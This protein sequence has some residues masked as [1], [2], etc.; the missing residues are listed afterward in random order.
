MYQIPGK[1][2]YPGVITE[3]SYGSTA[4]TIHSTPGN[5]TKLNTARYHR[6]YK[7]EDKDAMGQKNVH[8]GFSD[9]NLF[10]AQT[11]SPHISGLYQHSCIK[12][13]EP[14]HHT[15]TTCTD[16]EERFT[17]AIPLEVV[18]LTPLL[19]WNPYNIQHTTSMKNAD[20]HHIIHGPNGTR[21]GG[22]TKDKA[23]NGTHNK[24][25]YRTP[26]EFFSSK[27]S[28]DHDRAD[29]A[30]GSVGVL[31]QQGQVRQM[32]ASGIRIMLPKIEG[33]GR[34]RTRWPIVPI[35]AEGQHTRKE[36]EALKDMVMNMPTYSTL[37]EEMPTSVSQANKLFMET[38]HLLKIPP[39]SR[40]PP[41]LHD[42]DLVIHE[43]DIES[44]KQG[45]TVKGVL[46]SISNA[47]QHSVDIK[48][49]G[50]NTYI[51]TSCDGMARCWDGHDIHLS[52]ES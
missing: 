32:V 50:N 36:L 34:I 19:T 37:F 51:M 17:Y 16:L 5:M 8:R 3:S 23:Y 11:T 28:V 21:N 29:T 48:M 45:N 41:G 35:H 52:V 4:Y 24:L 7:I 6:W 39:T 46:S 42:H 25:Y 44:M 26:V 15:V 33:V 20:I 9:P 27:G 22:M 12:H 14:H 49:T 40:D 2:N 10:V 47:H 38:E 13:R 1:D 43:Y 30:K 18:Y 31:D